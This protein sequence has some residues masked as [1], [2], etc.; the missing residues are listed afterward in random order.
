ML[1]P[2]LALGLVMIALGVGLVAV[3][4]FTAG[5]E[6]KASLLGFNMGAESVFVAGIVA[7]V[8]ILLGF[9]MTRWGAASNWRH[10]QERKQYNKLAEKLG[11]EADH[12]AP[13]SPMPGHDQQL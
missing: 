10:R 4:L 6:G 3:G 12:N 1:G 8:L 13:P 5:D 9:Y 7:A 11:R 2:M